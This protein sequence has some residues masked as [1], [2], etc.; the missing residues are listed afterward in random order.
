MR[1]RRPL[2]R[3]YEHT[4]ICQPWPTAVNPNA[5]NA[6]ARCPRVV[7]ID[8]ARIDADAF[9]GGLDLANSDDFTDALVSVDRD[10]VAGRALDHHQRVFLS[11][12]KSVE[13]EAE[14]VYAHGVC[15]AVFIGEG[16][17]KLTELRRRS[18]IDANRKTSTAVGCRRAHRE[19]R[20]AVNAIEA[21]RRRG[22]EKSAN[23]ER[24]P[25]TAADCPTVACA[26]HA[27]E[28]RPHPTRG[29]H[30]DGALRRLVR[31]SV[32]VVTRSC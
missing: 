20:V 16:E 2:L 32:R 10:H 12:A 30:L 13:S 14:D 21:A 26:S 7:E 23:G 5:P 3:R 25:H 9:V 31:S 29:K 28:R 27:R 8:A 15:A 22:G 4:L 19:V 11:H 1:M 6:V 18:V 17:R 24:C